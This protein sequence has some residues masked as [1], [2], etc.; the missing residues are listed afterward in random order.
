MARPLAL[1]INAH[2]DHADLVT[3]FLAEQGESPLGDGLVRRH[4][5]GLDRGVL[6]DHGV[7]PI[8][9]FTDLVAGHG[10]GMGEVEAEPPGLDQRALLRH[11]G[12]KHLA[13][14]LMQ[15]MGRRMMGARRRAAGVVDLEQH[16]VAGA[17]T[18]RRH[19]AVM[20][21]KRVE[22]LLR[23]L[24]PEP[25]AVGAGKG[26]AIADLAAQLGIERRL[27]ED[28]DAALAF[29]QHV[30]PHAVLDDRHDLGGGGLGL[31]AEELGGAELLLQLEP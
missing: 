17:Q 29:I 1:G 28:H 27:V 13:E 22:L 25:C 18:A 14:R 15:K 6:E 5:M 30:D 16:L 7:H 9:H 2:A 31:V 23:V 19:H 8:L 11:M 26:A 20:E 3:I 12:P 21:I 24:D 10:L 4:Q